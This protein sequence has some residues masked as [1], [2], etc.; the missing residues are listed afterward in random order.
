MFCH[1]YLRKAALLLWTTIK[2]K[3]LSTLEALTRL[4]VLLYQIKSQDLVTYPQIHKHF[5]SIVCDL[6]SYLSLVKVYIYQKLF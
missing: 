3:Y 4:C 6:L 2:S 1:I 5:S